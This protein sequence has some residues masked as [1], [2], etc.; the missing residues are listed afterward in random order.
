MYDHVN[1]SKN[2]SLASSK[3]NSHDLGIKILNEVRYSV[4]QRFFLSV[5]TWGDCGSTSGT[6]RPLI[7]MESF[8]SSDCLLGISIVR[9][10]SVFSSES[11]NSANLNRG[12]GFLRGKL[13]GLTPPQLSFSG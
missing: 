12:V 7:S 3:I 1:L 10:L 2:R 8:A 13:R 9:C 5:L 6:L 11:I 4:L